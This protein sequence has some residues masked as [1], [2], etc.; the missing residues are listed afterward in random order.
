MG[1]GPRDRHLVSSR[2]AT[3]VESLARRTPS[4]EEV[5]RL[6]AAM[7]EESQPMIYLG[8]IPGL[9]F[10]EVAVV[11]VGRLDLIGKSLSVEGP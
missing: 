9:R 2:E 11:R 1:R 6:V 3:R 8:A 4:P 5:A 7:R 10:S